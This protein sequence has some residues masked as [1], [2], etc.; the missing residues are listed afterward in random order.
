MPYNPGTQY[1]GDVYTARSN[2][3]LGAAIGGVIQGVLND[4]KQAKALR[5]TL[6][7]YGPQEGD[8]AKAWKAH[9]DTL[10]KSELEGEMQKQT[11]LHAMQQEQQ[12]N[13]QAAQEHNSMQ[14][15]RAAQLEHFNM[16]SAAMKQE[17][18][19][20]SRYGQLMA[21]AD[22]GNAANPEA[23]QIGAQ[24]L[25]SPGGNP[26]VAAALERMA[27]ERQ[28]TPQDRM[29]MMIRAGM[30]P[31]QIEKGT[32]AEAN[33][34]KAMGGQANDFM[35]VPFSVADINGIVSPRTGS[36]HVK[37]DTSGANGTTLDDT[38]RKMSIDDAYK[39]RRVALASQKGWPPESPQFQEA[40]RQ[41]DQIDTVLKGGD[42]TPDTGNA[43]TA[44]NAKGDKVIFKN[45][46]WQPFKP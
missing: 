39:R 16:Q 35:P 14:A 10:G 29:S 27:M 1:R 41:I 34:Q 7:A 23:G 11:L 43:P 32:Q 30:S 46:A 44:T 13:A 3:E 42:S 21:Q 24:M 38:L 26:G 12:R 8:A 31:A 18:A 17:A 37:T 28:T 4:A 25:A 19:A 45:G 5:G 2:E 22:A 6:T 33:L 20:Q 15:L 9:L 36:I 40:Q